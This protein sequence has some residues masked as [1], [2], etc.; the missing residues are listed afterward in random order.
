MVATGAGTDASTNYYNIGRPIENTVKIYDNAHYAHGSD[1]LK[2]QLEQTIGYVYH[3]IDKAKHELLTQTSQNPD[4]AM[5]ADYQ[6][7]LVS[8]YHFYDPAN[9]TETSK[10]TGNEYEPKPSATELTSLASLNATYETPVSSDEATW[11]DA[12]EGRKLEA[13]SYD[14]MTEKAKQLG[15]TGHYYFKVSGVSVAYHDVNVTKPFYNHIYVT[16]DANDIVKFGNTSQYTLKFLEPLADGYYLEDGNDKLT[17][18]KLQAVYP[19]TN[20]DGNLNIYSQEMKDEQMAGGASTRPRWVWYFNSTNND[21]YHV[22]IHSRST[23][24]YSGVS[25]PTYLQTYAVHFNQDTE[26]PKQERIVT[27]GGL[28]GV[29]SAT[30]TEYMI[31]G[32]QG[33]YKL[34][35]TY[36][37]VADLDGDGNTTGSGE[38]ERRKVTS[39]EQ[40]WKTYDTVR[41]K[42]LNQPKNDT[43]PDDDNDPITVPETPCKVEGQSNNRTYL[44]S[45]I[46]FHHYEKW[47]YAKRW[48]GYNNGYSSTEGTHETKK[49]WEKIEHLGNVVIGND[50]EIGANTTV[51]RA[52]M[53]STIIGNG[54]KIDNLCQIAHNVIIGDHTAMAA[55]CGIAGSTQIGKYCILAGQVGVAGHLKIADHTTI[56]AQG[57]VIGNIR[58]EGEVLVGSPVIPVKQYMKAYAIFKR[59]AEE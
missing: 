58:K 4:L 55:Q 18:T 25:H 10:A 14:N 51:D 48:N 53:E 30:P 37:V 23:I 12:G 54:V 35:T 22:R 56:C 21:P 41:R 3:L 33:A 38:N 46:G 26:K 24:S 5:P 16:Y 15:E 27:G 29:A 45:V 59:Q 42:L 7:P 40:Y 20:G 34:M 49:G 50:V 8:K 2:F 36:P 28:P 19:Y 57:G 44:E 11:S 13:T 32:A 6:S 43:Y 1:I 31:L 47:A 9:I 39:F 17:T 52:Q